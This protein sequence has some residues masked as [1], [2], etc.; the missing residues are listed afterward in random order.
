MPDTLDKTDR[1]DTEFLADFVARFG[2]LWRKDALDARG[3]WG[4]RRRWISVTH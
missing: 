1:P 4:G 2:Q 3:I